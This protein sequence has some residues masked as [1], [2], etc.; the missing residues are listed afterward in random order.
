M[1]FSILQIWIFENKTQ[2][3]AHHAINRCMSE[4]GQVHTHPSRG[5]NRSHMP[6]LALPASRIAHAIRGV[7]SRPGSNEGEASV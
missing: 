6:A 7:H 4:K 1:R 5:C 2:L 3:R